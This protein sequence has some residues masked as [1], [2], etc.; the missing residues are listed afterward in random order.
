MKE[1]FYTNTQGNKTENIVERIAGEIKINYGERIV[2]KSKMIVVLARNRRK[3]WALDQIE[4]RYKSE[5]I[6]TRR[7]GGAI[8]L[9]EEK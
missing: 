5:V 4:D 8:L 3:V 6:I 7:R 1:N 2:V 9:I